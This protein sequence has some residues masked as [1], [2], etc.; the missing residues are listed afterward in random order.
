[1]GTHTLSGRPAR[2]RAV[3]LASVVTLTSAVS[4]AVRA[5]DSP[6]A[7]AARAGDPALVQELVANGASVNQ[8]HNDGTTPLLWAAY[9]SHLDSVTVLLEHGADP[10]A[11]N[12]LGVTPL[13]QA[14]RTGDAPVMRAL[15]DGG[16]S[17]VVGGSP[18]EPVLHAAAR[19][20][21]V[22]AVELLLERG[23]DPNATEPHQ[24]QTALM[25]AAAEGHLGVVDALLAGGAD[26]NMQARESELSKRSTRTDFPTGG[27]TALMWAAREGNEVIVRRLV[28]GGADLNIANGDGATPLMLAIINDRF[29][30]AAQLLELGADP[31]TDGSL[32]Y[33]VL[34]RD[35]TTDWL[36]KDGSRL[37]RDYPNELTALDLIERLLAAGADPNKPFAGQMHS[38]SMCC[39]TFENGSPFFR[40]ARRRRGD[41]AAPR[42]R[43]RPRVVARA[44]RGGLGPGGEQPR[45][46]DAAD[47]RDGRRQGR[48]HGRRAGRHS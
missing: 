20:G 45:R 13:L 33:A 34:M 46:Q 8:A 10:D 27:F 3:L 40:A 6:L 2:L 12:D 11:A 1:M 37:R 26:P 14:A 4:L 44:G 32:Y 41:R 47:G 17:I 19:S 39:D 7:D 25:W 42:A 30:F 29:D 36:A 38:T 18:F 5:A 24:E 23:S 43:R 48:R 31:R 22:E 28:E 35:A 9:H 15:L 21:S 16:A